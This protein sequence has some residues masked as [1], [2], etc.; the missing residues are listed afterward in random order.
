MYPF[1]VLWT[2]I[3]GRQKTSDY[4]RLHL[5]LQGSFCA[6][7]VWKLVSRGEWGIL[8]PAV[9]LWWAG[10]PWQ[11]CSA[12]GHVPGPRQHSSGGVKAGCVLRHWGR[13]PS[14]QAI[15]A[16]QLLTLLVLEWGTRALACLWDLA[17]PK[18]GLSQG[19]TTGQLEYGTAE[20]IPSQV[21]N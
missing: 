1:G 7:T 5:W 19:S 6:C 11:C 15:G 14:K 20:W 3:R 8:S 10:Q 17:V 2:C 18:P 12:F 13:P 4:L 9:C 21:P 16:L